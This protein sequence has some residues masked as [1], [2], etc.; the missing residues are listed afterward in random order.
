MADS[1]EVQFAALCHR[2]GYGRAMHLVEHLWRDRAAADGRSGSE[3][4]V[5]PCAALMTICPCVA[6]GE[7]EKCDWCCGVRIVTDRVRRAIRSSSIGPGKI[8]HA[9]DHDQGVSTATLTQGERMV[10]AVAFERGV[11]EG[12]RSH[13]AAVNARAVVDRMRAAIDANIDDETRSMLEQMLADP[14]RSGVR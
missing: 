5:G 6:R 7:S 14:A 9:P 4:T 1:V 11:F 8:A 12:Q 10:W 2:I 3:F 13:H